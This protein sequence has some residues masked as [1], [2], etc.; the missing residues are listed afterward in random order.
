MTSVPRSAALPSIGTLSSQDY[1]QLVFFSV[2]GYFNAICDPATDET[3]NV[4]EIQPINALVTF[5]PRLQIGQLLFMSDYL[6]TSPFNAVQ[7]VTLV[8]NV[9]G[10]TFTLTYQGQTTTALDWDVASADLQSALEALS[11]IGAG[12][13]SVTAGQ[14]PESWD[15]EFVAALGNQTITTM[16]GNGTELTNP[17]GGGF[18]VVTVAVTEAGSGMVIGDTA[19]C[20]PTLTARIFAGVLS[21]IDYV[22]TPGFQL[23]AN[24]GA[25]NIGGPLIYDVSFSSVTFNQANQYLAPFAFYAPTDSTPVCLT[26]PGLEKLDWAAPSS[27]VWSPPTGANQP[28][29][30]RLVPG[31]GGYRGIA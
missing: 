9:T 15:V 14:A 31:C 12:N 16:T 13:V 30:L 18:S 11:T 23:P 4:P 27:V 7:V 5:R 29:E 28:L 8:G 26:D 2:T 3:V 22:D 1:T 25:L 19:I 20:L 10:G 17:Q 24:I 6:I 21:T